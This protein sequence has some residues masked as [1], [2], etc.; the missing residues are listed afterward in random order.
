MKHATRL[1]TTTNS[2]EHKNFWRDVLKG[3]DVQLLAEQHII[4]VREAIVHKVLE[5]F[6]RNSYALASGKISSISLS[7]PYP[8]STTWLTNVSILNERL[9]MCRAN[10]EEET[11]EEHNR[12]V[13]LRANSRWGDPC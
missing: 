12:H 9:S 13:L 2:A 6:A 1:S 7:R 8:D 5:H 4:V 11:K 10:V 3:P